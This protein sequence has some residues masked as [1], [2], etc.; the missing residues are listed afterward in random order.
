M[1]EH[2]KMLQ[3]RCR[4]C[5]RKPTGYMHKKQSNTCASLLFSMLG[6]EATSESEDIFPPI[7]CNSCY[8]TLKRAR[9]E[10]MDIK[11]TT[12]SV[13]TWEPHSDFCQLCLESHSGGRPKKR[14]KGR[15][16]EDDP[17]FQRRKIARRLEELGTSEMASLEDP[18][19]RSLF[20]PSPYFHCHCISTQPVELATC[21][22]YLC[23]QCIRDGI[24]TCPCGG[25]EIHV[26]QLNKPSPLSLNLI[27][28]LLVHCSNNCG[29][30]MELRHLVAHLSSNCEN[31]TIPS[32]SKISEAATG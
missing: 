26:D 7:V 15:L 1:E 13:H 20:L 24:A 17:T 27:S 6:I 28:S 12:L 4:V 29:E 2:L 14:R 31:T 19:Q 23:T 22:H 21:R 25:N 9:E 30:V 32:P 10:G 5:A 16:S 3:N 18:L 8:I 11:L